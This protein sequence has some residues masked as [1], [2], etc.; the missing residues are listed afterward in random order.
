MSA[1]QRI[2][3][4]SHA[5]TDALAARDWEA[6]RELDRQCRACVDALSVEDRADETQLRDKLEGLLAVYR[7]LLDVSRGE[8]AAIVDEMSQLKHAH[9]A[10]KVYHLFR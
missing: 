9:N 4:T 8:R 2:E 6:I 1:L 5:L 10:A 7:Q 3:D